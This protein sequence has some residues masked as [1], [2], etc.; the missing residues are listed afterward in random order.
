V[1]LVLVEMGGA[2]T[3][4]VAV[5][6][7]RIVDGLG[8]SAGPMGAAG[9]G[10][11]DGEVAFLLGTITKGTLF[12]GGART[13][14]GTDGTE[15]LHRQTPAAALAREAY[16]DSLTKAVAAMLVTVPAP[17]EIVLSGR[18]SEAGALRDPLV[19]RLH[20]LRPQADV[21]PL[22]RLSPGVK[23]AAYGAALVADG[24]AGGRCAPIV[25]HLG[26]R[27]A[28]GTALDHLHVISRQAA[29]RR[30]GLT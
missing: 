17:R 4:V 24:L 7:G 16:L 13:I 21:H 11:L 25:N 6:G 20:A 18:L 29:R 19:G 2:F 26:L 10:A 3:A 14:A 27:A 9:S 1:S 23:H 12:G 30:L 5:E 22:G 15:W 28:A 8:G